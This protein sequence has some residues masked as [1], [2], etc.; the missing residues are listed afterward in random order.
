MSGTTEQEVTLKQGAG[1][2]VGPS[3]STTAGEKGKK[4]IKKE[5]F[6]KT[7]ARQTNTFRL[8]PGYAEKEVHCGFSSPRLLYSSF[9]YLLLAFLKL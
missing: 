8:R 6:T 9:I 3:P 7:P 2:T 4:K 1:T 5:W